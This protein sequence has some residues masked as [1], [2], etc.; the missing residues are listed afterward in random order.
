MKEILIDPH[1]HTYE[2]SPCGKV[3]AAQMIELYRAA[4]YACVCVTDHYYNHHFEKMGDIPWREKVA[5]YIR[6]YEAAA[7]AGKKL[8]VRVLFGQEIR[9]FDS[10]NDYIVFGFSP[11]DLVR[12]PELYNM[13]LAEYSAFARAHGAFLFQAHPFRSPCV[14][15]DPVLL[16]GTEVYN[17]HPDHA[18][19]NG[20]ALAY[21]EEHHLPQFSGTD[22]HRWH[23]LAR[24]GL[25]LREFPEDEKAFVQ[26]LKSYDIV[27][28]V[29]T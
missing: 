16:D 22:F 19:H 26:M 23:H 2:V 20:L 11:D 6:G 25:S 9:F 1:V 24:G 18:N 3:P 28:L 13:T 15:A 10:I 27:R 21:A 17:G 7:D 5:Q 14:P 29:Q 4:G 12:Y 8:G